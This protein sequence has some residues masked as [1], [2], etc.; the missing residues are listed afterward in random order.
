MPDIEPNLH[1]CGHDYKFERLLQGG[2]SGKV[3]LCTC[4][5]DSHHVVIKAMKKEE[6][7]EEWVQNE[8]KAGKILRHKGLCEFKECFE[9]EHYKYIVME[10]V[11]GNDMWEFMQMRHWTPLME[12]EARQVVR[13]IA[14][15]LQFCHK[16][17]VAH[18]DIKLENVMVDKKLH[19]TLID[20]GF[21]EVCQ[22]KISL[23]NRFDGTLDYMPPE[24]LLHIPFDPFKADVFALGVLMF[25]CLTGKFPFDWKDRYKSLCCGRIPSLNLES[26]EFRE[27]SKPARE[28]LLGMLRPIPDERFTLAECLSHEWLKKESFSHHL[29]EKLESLLPLSPSLNKAV[30]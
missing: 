3:M 11:K 4:E 30:R 8:T 21:C 7:K 20:F 10:Y 16:Q 14:K 2:R 18:K 27:L 22:D 15:S 17:G 5:K 25:V 28:L 26:K 9:D 19:T 12:K 13:Q 29:I 1:F 24:E 6:I 23:S